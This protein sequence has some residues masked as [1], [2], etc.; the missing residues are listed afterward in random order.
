MLEVLRDRLVEEI[1][2]IL[3]EWGCASAVSPVPVEINEYDDAEKGLLASPVAFQLAGERGQPPAEIAAELAES[4]SGR[5]A[6]GWVDRIESTGPYLNVYVDDDHVATETMARILDAG[7]S[8]GVV[9]DRNWSAVFEFSSP[10]VAKPMH[11]G[12]LRNT[13]LGDVLANVLDAQG[14]ELIRDNHIGDW[15]VQFGHMLYEYEQADDTERFETEPIAYLLDLYQRYGSQEAELA[16]A[17]DDDALE[18]L[19]DTGRSYFARLEDG[20][21][22]LRE[23]WEAF[24][25]ASIERFT[26]TYDR[27]GVEFDTWHGE[28]YYVIESW[29]SQIRSEALDRSI[30]VEA[31]DGAQ[32]IPVFDD[33]LDGVESPETADVRTGPIDELPED[34]DSY[35]SLVLEKR[36]GTTTY[37]TRDLATIAYRVAEGFDELIYVVAEEQ[38]E[39]FQQVFAAARKLGFT[40]VTFTHV[41]YGM[42]DLPEGSMSTRAGRM[43]S[44]VDVLDRVHEEALSVVQE[45]YPELSEDEA[46][47]I[48][49]GVTLGTVTFENVDKRRTKNSTFDIEQ[50]TS[51][52]GDT[53]P[54]VQYAATRGVNILDRVEQP[55]PEPASVAD[56][57][58]NEYDY[59]LA[60]ELARYPLVLEQSRDRY[61]PS[62]LVQYLLDLARTFNKFYHENRVI[63]DET[64]RERRLTLVAAAVTVFEAGFE[65]ANV[66]MLDRM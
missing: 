35:G 36:D 33:E 64:V 29:T 55:V 5:L 63:D 42:V 57:A 20:D 65:L 26:E 2:A 60:V 44:A 66:P 18:A 54:Y 62:P 31:D 4:L 17:G 58:F 32:I 39:Y 10:N 16:D 48:A 50:A 23:R 51:L 14:Y 59:Q 34:D 38:R 49:E 1:S 7:T 25:A 41:E 52:E 21:P 53:G 9:D 28:S 43:I 61:D 37:G 46:S 8:Y 40:D 27:L 3:R 45:N 47:Q 19:R 15:G 6:E 12:H 13:V 24:S 11:I 22:T 56:E 30:A